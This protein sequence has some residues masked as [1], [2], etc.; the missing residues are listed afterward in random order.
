MEPTSVLEQIDFA[1]VRRFPVDFLLRHHFFPFREDERTLWVWMPDPGDLQALSVIEGHVGKRVLPRQVG[2]E[3]L[4]QLFKRVDAYTEVLSRKTGQYLAQ[5]EEEGDGDERV[6]TLESL[7]DGDSSV[8][9]LLNNLI[10]TAVTKR[11][12][13]IH[14]EAKERELV[15]K[16]RIDGILVSPMAP[17]GGEVLSPLLT[18]LK[19]LAELDIA[20]RRIPQ[21][22]RF[23]LRFRNKT[24]DFRLSVLPGVFGENAVIRILDREMVTRSLE[25]LSLATLGFSDD[26]IE[27]MDHH[28]RLPYGMFLVTGPTGSGKTTSLYAALNA[29][30]S[31]EE[32]V[33]TIEDPVEYQMEGVLQIPV[34]EKKGLTFARGLRS[35]LRHDPDRIMVGEIRDPE[36]AQIAIQSALTG[37][38]VYTTVHANN[39]F[40]V[41]GRFIHMGVDA[42][43]F[44]SALSCIL[45]QR[46]VRTLC[47]HCRRPVHVTEQELLAHRLRPGQVPEP[48]YEPVGCTACN[49][50]GFLGRTAIGEILELSDTVKEMILERKPTSEIRKVAMAEGMI[51]IR[52]NGLM[53][54][55]RAQTTLSELDRVTAREWLV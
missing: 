1:L 48:L 21:D 10:F 44:V 31:K 38:M 24:I 33:V 17:L 29:I 19:V 18:R 22:W 28:I 34:N 16:Y 9:Q 8:V 14:L 13:D 37:H 26:L 3:V 35:I 45:A 39:V 20:E 27:Q 41:L 36:T 15:V 5:Q 12:S 47:P 43:S 4:D 51:P 30:R 49:G 42:Y 7:S 50:V 32:K 55:A 25:D 40:D 23:R 53:K 2:E 54:V 46:L 11:A 6:I 52:R